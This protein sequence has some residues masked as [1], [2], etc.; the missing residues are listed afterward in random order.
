MGCE[1]TRLLQPKARKDRASENQEQDKISS[2]LPPL[3]YYS[4]DSER[5][6]DKKMAETIYILTIYIKSRASFIAQVFILNGL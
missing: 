2:F 6:A 5:K 4:H 1:N 3:R